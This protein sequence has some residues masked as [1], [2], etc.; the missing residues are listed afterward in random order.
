MTMASRLFRMGSHQLH[1][2]AAI[3][4]YAGTVVRLLPSRSV[5]TA[6]YSETIDQKELFL[7]LV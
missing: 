5:L 1:S 3:E 7:Q 2:F 6:D 4:T